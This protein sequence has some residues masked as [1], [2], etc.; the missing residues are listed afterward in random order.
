MTPAP[1]GFELAIYCV[2]IPMP[3]VNCFFLLTSLQGHHCKKEDSLV[4]NLL[5]E[6][7]AQGLIRH[8]RQGLRQPC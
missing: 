3:E 8:L 4:S 1:S 7:L 2:E 6:Y 5:E